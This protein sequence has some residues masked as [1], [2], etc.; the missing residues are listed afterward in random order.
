MLRRTIPVAMAGVALVLTG[1][2][3]EDSAGP[4]T[5]TGP[6]LPTT[7]SAAPT[8][9]ES[10]GPPRS[11][12][13]HI[14]KELGE[15]GGFTG[16]DDADAPLVLNFTVDSITVDP[17][18]S[19]SFVQQPANGHYIAIGLRASTSPE[20]DPSTYLT[21][22]E[23]DF[24]VIGPDGLTVSDVSGN[25]YTCLADNQRFT[26]DA[27]G[28]GQQ[29]A[30]TVVIDAPASHGT[31]VYAPGAFGGTSGWEWAF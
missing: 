25:A 12:R 10:T 7:S 19:S 31:L 28:P 26:S 3:T 11:E 8:T 1:C 4:A 18:C 30:G 23:Y 13:G 16:S 6:E 15:E 24:Q 9:S 5:A 20:F 17:E 22:T 21:F 27:L 29:Y 2:S 14:I